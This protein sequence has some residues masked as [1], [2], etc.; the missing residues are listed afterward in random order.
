MDEQGTAYYNSV[1]GKAFTI[2]VRWW[3]YT[4]HRYWNNEKAQ[5]VTKTSGSYVTMKTVKFTAVTKTR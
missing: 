1:P 4:T 3:V 5:F 2:S